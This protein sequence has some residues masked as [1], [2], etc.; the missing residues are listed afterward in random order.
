MINN[1]KYATK[2]SFI[3]K[4]KKT[5]LKIFNI[6]TEAAEP[7]TKEEMDAVNITI[8]KADTPSTEEVK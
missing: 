1:H 3:K 8:D 2:A 7:M 6:Y 5:L 4:F